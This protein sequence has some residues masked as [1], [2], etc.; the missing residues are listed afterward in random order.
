MTLRC[1]ACEVKWEATRALGDRCS[2]CGRPA[3]TDKR[4]WPV[5]N[6]SDLPR[7]MRNPL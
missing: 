2:V 3:S 6:P 7:E 4:G 5:L 1:N